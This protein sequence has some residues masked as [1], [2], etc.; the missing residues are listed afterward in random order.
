M[1]EEHPEPAIRRRA[2]VG[3]GGREIIGAVQRFDHDAELAQVVAP[4]VFEQLGVVLALDPD[5]AGRGHPAARPSPATEPDAV[6]RWVAAFAVAGRTS[7]TGLPSIRKPPGFH[8][9]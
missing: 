7:V 5:P 2:E 1:I 8:V 4:H 9:K 3:D 6:I